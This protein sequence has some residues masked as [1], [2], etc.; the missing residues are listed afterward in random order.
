VSGGGLV[1]ADTQAIEGR[2]FQRW[3]GAPAAG[4]SIAIGFGGGGTRW[5][6]PLLVGAVAFALLL[7]LTRVLRRPATS[8][9]PAASPLLDQLARLDARY[10]GH[11]A[12]ASAAEWRRYQEERA[13]LKAALA[14][15]L[16]R[17][18]AHP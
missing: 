15:E 6:L 9:A 8:G 3:A 13:A 4:S 5:L 17:K 1:A 2:T 10:A 11:E 7:V 18:G 14:E 12:E 16:A